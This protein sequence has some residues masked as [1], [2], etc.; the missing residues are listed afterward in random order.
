MKKQFLSVASSIVFVVRFHVS[1][2]A[3]LMVADYG[4]MG[5]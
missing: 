2:T 1:S 5:V 4:L 3:C